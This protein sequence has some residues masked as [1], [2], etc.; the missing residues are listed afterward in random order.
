ASKALKLCCR[1]SWKCVLHLCEMFVE[2]SDVFHGDL[3][4]DAI[5]GFV[6]EACSK[7]AFLLDV[8]SQ[9][10]SKK[11]NRIIG[12]SLESWSAAQNLFEELPSPK[13]LVMQWVKELLAYKEMNAL[14]PRFCRRMRM[15]IIGILLEVVYVMKDS[16]L[17]K[18][19]ILLTKGRELR[20]CGIKGL[21]ECIPCLSAAISTLNEVCGETF[22]CSIQVRHQL[23]EAYCLR[24]LCTQEAEPNSKQLF[25]DIRAALNLWSSP[26]HCHEAE[27]S[28]MIPEN[29]LILLYN[30]VDLLSVKGCMNFHPEVFE[31]LIRLFKWKG[32]P[33]EKCLAMLWEYR[34]LGHALCASSVNE[35]FITTLS[36]HCGELSQSID[37]W[38]SCMKGSEAQGVGFQQN[39]SLMFQ[40]DIKVEEVKKAA[41][42]L[43]SS[44]RSFL[45]AIK[46]N[47]PS[48]FRLK[49]VSYYQFFS[50][51]VRS[52]YPVVQHLL[53][54]ICTMTC[55]RNW[56]QVED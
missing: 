44:V 7:S 26:D 15:D 45:L 42:E 17:Q 20:A 47:F 55:L 56:F 22:S 4:E 16:C 41:S 13:A 11:V 49:Q 46:S 6:T 53:L 14:N 10:D 39:F 1:A 9:Y 32:V 5:V 25:Q 52:L 19:Q 51:N 37:F 21:D 29:T 18:S 2:K 3:S 40:S 30:V 33:L 50:F 24:A 35:S 54:R 43:L 48:K 12:E 27:H 36:R 23:A 34:R 31:I 28:N 38:I 8:L